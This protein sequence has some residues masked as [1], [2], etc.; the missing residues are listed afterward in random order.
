[1]AGF[2]SYETTQDKARGVFHWNETEVKVSASTT[3]TY[4]P[5]GVIVTRLCASRGMPATPS[6]EDC[7]VDS[8]FNILQVRKMI[9]LEI[10][11]D[12]IQRIR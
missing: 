12:D 9:S 5:P 6:I 10:Q 2:C 7:R 3:C 8:Y 11:I 4:G 1:M